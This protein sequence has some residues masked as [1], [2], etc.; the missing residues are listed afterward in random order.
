[1]FVL[2]GMCSRMMSSIP[3]LA[4]SMSA[5]S[6]G[7]ISGESDASSRKVARWY[8]SFSFAEAFLSAG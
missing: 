1:M 5:S 4:C 8:K 6:S 7:E 3:A 2:R